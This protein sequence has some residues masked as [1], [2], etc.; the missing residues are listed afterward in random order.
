LLISKISFWSF[1]VGYYIIVLLLPYLA[2]CLRLKQ[3]SPAW[4]FVLKKVT[5]IFLKTKTP[6]K[7][8]GANYYKNVISFSSYRTITVG[9]GVTYSLCKTESQTSTASGESHPAPKN[10]NI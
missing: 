7:Y 9:I 5:P 6:Y 2:N 10:K 3:K 8:T 4:V 1:S